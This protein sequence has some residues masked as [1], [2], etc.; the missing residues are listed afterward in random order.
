MQSE[1][2]V[3]T[4]NLYCSIS[5][6]EFVLQVM[7]DGS[8]E[9]N[10]IVLFIWVLHW[11]HSVWRHKQAWGL[12]QMAVEEQMNSPAGLVHDFTHWSGT[13]WL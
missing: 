1:A 11:C 3:H 10:R 6:M 7:A 13:S 9:E 8:S 12:T 5:A 4:S 2:D